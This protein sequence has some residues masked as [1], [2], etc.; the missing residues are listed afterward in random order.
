MQRDLFD[1]K[2]YYYDFQSDIAGLGPLRDTLK[3]AETFNHNGVTWEIIEREDINQCFVIQKV[4]RTDDQE[5]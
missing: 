3:V 1:D 5:F 2:R 4:N